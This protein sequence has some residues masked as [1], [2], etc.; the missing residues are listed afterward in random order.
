MEYKKDFLVIGS[1]IAGL[2][3]ALKVADYGTVAVITKKD[4]MEGNTRYAQGGIASV[5]DPDDSFDLHIEDTLQAGDG[6]CK[7][8]VVEMV[9]KAGPDRIREL[10]DMGVPFTLRSDGK[11][12]DL[13][14]EGGHSRNRIVHANDMSGREIER[15]LAERSR[16]HKNITVFENHV[17]I[18]LITYSKSLK[19]GL[20][21][22]NH[23]DFCCGAYALDISN[24]EVHTFGAKI[25]VL[26]TGGS[27]KVYLY[28]SNPDVATGA[29]IAMGY[30]AGTK[31]ANLEFVQFH[32]TCLYHPEA[33][34]FLISEAVRGEG[35]ILVNAKGEAFM[36]NYDPLKDLACRDVVARSI[37]M[38]LKKSG[39]ESVY[40]DITHLDSDFII[41]RFPNIYKKCL[42][43]GID[44][45]KEPIPVVPAAHYTCGGIV[46][47]R[48]GRTNIQRLYA[49]GEV[50]CTGLHGAN[51]LASNSLLE[52]LVFAHEA[53][54]QSTQDLRS[55]SDRT[56][57]EVS[58]WDPG[59]ATDS[60]EAIMVSHNWDEIRRFMWNYVG[61]V[62]SNKRL[63]RAKHR[64]DNIKQEILEYYWDFKVTS[65]IIE[66][67]N[68]A[69]VADMIIQC[70]MVRKESRGLHYNLRYPYKD[71]KNWQKDTV[72]CRRL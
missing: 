68:I 48:A 9:V 2:S 39:D 6:L 46:T 59:G 10:F 1:G 24:N 67:R 16:E 54:H 22:A 53:A 8:S 17:A 71:D 13:G 56:V 30:R 70:A 5:F 38:E 34:N 69:E 15:T 65:N 43:F 4:I 64:I 57:P 21:T 19:R 58:A 62:R 63:S 45:T 51:R 55:I 47:D 26:A 61:I 36:E 14:L 32:P 42:F 44:I 41:N 66:L 18:D 31:V 25:T 3:F 49:I 40:L 20:I 50:A 12:F 29:G 33:K 72:L 52:A 27:A 60:D 35:G 11:M 37:D 7:R 28:T 23:E